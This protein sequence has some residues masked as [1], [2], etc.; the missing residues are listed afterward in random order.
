MKITKTF[1]FDAAHW[2]PHVPK[3]HRCSRMH[4][5]TY[6]VE[7][8]LAGQPTAEQGWLVDFAT[9]GRAWKAIAVEVD[10]RCLNDVQG[11]ENPT[12]EVL[13]RWLLLRWREELPACHNYEV[14]MVRVKESSTTSCEIEV[15]DL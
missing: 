5:H 1:T 7:V 4:G 3:T 9:I 2:L 8:K 15:A 6:H 12:C 11:L 14:V 13:A 10:H